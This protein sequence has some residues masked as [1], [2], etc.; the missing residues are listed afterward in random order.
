M[1]ALPECWF[2]T[3]LTAPT[4]IRLTTVV[5]TRLR[6]T[7]P[8]TGRPYSPTTLPTIPTPQARSTI[9]FTKGSD[10]PVSGNSFSFTA[11]A[12]TIYTLTYSGTPDT[13]P[14]S[15]SITSPS[16]GATVSGVTT[17]SATAADDVGVTGVQF[18]VDGTN[19][20]S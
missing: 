3:A 14:P 10:V 17:V 9:N 2:G 5:K 8:V 19:I 18:K 11:P 12:N 4:S 20:G 7:P 13:S 6:M 15:V 1:K 16:G